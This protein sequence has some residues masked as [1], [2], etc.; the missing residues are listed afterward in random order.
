MALRHEMHV[1]WLTPECRECRT[2][3]Q[4]SGNLT[5]VKPDH[6]A[7]VCAAAVCGH[8][9]T[10]IVRASNIGSMVTVITSSVV[11]T[12]HCTDCTQG[13]DSDKTICLPH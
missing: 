13:F 5:A 6:S 4:M 3:D 8:L 10:D 9:A 7:A 12:D 1:L 11:T 2:A